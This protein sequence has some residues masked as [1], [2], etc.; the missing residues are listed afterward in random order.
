MKTNKSN[1][2]VVFFLY[3]Y[4][5]VHRVKSIQQSMNCYLSRMSETGWEECV[6]LGVSSPRLV[7]GDHGCASASCWLFAAAFTFI[8]GKLLEATS[9][10]FI[11]HRLPLWVITIAART[12]I[13]SDCIIMNISVLKD[14]KTFYLN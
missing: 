8:I 4:L 7:V 5:A 9:H 13:S 11:I 2:F 6:F 14:E 1:Y 3:N 12:D 10:E